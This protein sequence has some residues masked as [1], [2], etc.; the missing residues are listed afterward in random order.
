MFMI[1]SREICMLRNTRQKYDPIFPAFIPALYNLSSTR[2]WEWSF[3]KKLCPVLK[4]FPTVSRINLNY[5]AILAQAPAYPSGLMSYSFLCHASFPA[6]LATFRAS[7]QTFPF[8]WNAL[9]SNTHIGGSFP[10]SGLSSNVTFSEKFF[11]ESISSQLAT[12]LSLYRITVLF[13][14]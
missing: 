12:A 3:K 13:S 10:D 8:A 2:Q 11:L 9:P 4:W 6:V 1:K 5:T 14:S 7:A